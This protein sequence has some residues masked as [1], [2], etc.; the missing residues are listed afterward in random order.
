MARRKK[1]SG[2]S[3]EAFS[4]L[5]FTVGSAVA[6]TAGRA[7]LAAIRAYM[8]APLRNTALAS[9]VTPSAM[10]GSNALYKQSH[11]H[12]APMFGTF[13]SKPKAVRA[14]VTPVVP[15]ARPSKF[16]VLQM[17]D[18]TGSVDPAAVTSG[19]IGNAE[20]LEVQRKLKAFELFDGKVDGLFGPR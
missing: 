11:H 8:Q 18:T 16:D 3:V 9:L 13:E 14:K 10:A 12:P 20:V 5:P 15:A 6:A 17:P 19:P 2:M 7:V 1:T 4:S